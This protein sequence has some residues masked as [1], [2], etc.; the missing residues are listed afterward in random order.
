MS[1]IEH[2][3]LACLHFDELQDL[4]QE[5]GL[6]GVPF[7]F[8]EGPFVAHHSS[9]GCLLRRVVLRIL[10]GRLCTP[11]LIRVFRSLV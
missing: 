2:S 3:S 8:G 1:A 7:L 11:I 9:P 6:L 4:D 10:G 5:T